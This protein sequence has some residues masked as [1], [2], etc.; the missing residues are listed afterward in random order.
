MPPLGPLEWIQGEVVDFGDRAHVYVIEFW[1]TWCGPC[2]Q[3]FPHLGELQERYKEQGLVVVGL[4]SG[5]KDAPAVQDFLAK[6]AKPVGIRIAFDTDRRAWRST[7]EAAG[8]ESIPLTLVLDRAGRIAFLDHPQR[9]LDQVIERVLEGTWDPARDKPAVSVKTA[10][11]REV[12]AL[13]KKGKFEEVDAVL[14]AAVAKDPSLAGFADKTRFHIEYFDRG[15]CQR[16]YKV[17]SGMLIGPSGED[18]DSLADVAEWIINEGQPEFRDYPLAR[19]LAAQA[20]ERTSW[21]DGPIID[22]LA[23]CHAHLG[24]L[25]KAVQLQTRAVEATPEGPAKANLA[26]TLRILRARRD[27]QQA[28][29]KR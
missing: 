16:A 17:A 3:Q 27:A 26:E 20:V 9:G 12:R 24:E 19:E 13:V 4:A 14:G 23:R 15:S 6:R 1:A 11:S 10:V 8:I 2:I 25:D 22:I 18:A 21:K 29:G 28:M 7:A 5:D